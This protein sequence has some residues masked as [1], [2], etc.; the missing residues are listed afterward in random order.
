MTQT[1]ESGYAS[2]LSQ[3]FSS[4]DTTMYVATPPTVTA[5]RV[6]LTDGSQKERVE[7]TG[8]SGSTLT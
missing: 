3:K 5:G 4:T 1:F 7:F 6:Y 2:T 8:V